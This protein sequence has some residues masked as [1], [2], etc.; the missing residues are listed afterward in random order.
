M[1]RAVYISFSRSSKKSL[2]KFHPLFKKIK[3]LNA[4]ASVNAGAYFYKKQQKVVFSIIRTKWDY[5]DLHRL[6][7]HILAVQLPL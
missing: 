1:D 5:I 2:F 7:A 3:L 6:Y 4:V